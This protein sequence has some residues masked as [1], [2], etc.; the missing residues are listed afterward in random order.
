MA[1]NGMADQ[2]ADKAREFGEEAL[3]RAEEWLK[4]VGLHQRAAHD[5]AP[6]VGGVGL[7]GGSI[8]GPAELA[9]AVALRRAARDPI[10]SATSWRMALSQN[11]EGYAMRRWIA[12]AVVGGLLAVPVRAFCQT[13][14]ESSWPSCRGR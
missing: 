14:Q 3:D 12:G 9:S 6:V 8:L 10:R 2:V 1:F 13:Q 11:M 5:R 7:R 4:P